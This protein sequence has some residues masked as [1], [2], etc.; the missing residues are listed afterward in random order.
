MIVNI[1]HRP[2]AGEL[3]DMFHLQQKFAHD[4][5]LKV[6]VMMPYDFLFDPEV[7]KDVKGYHLLYN[8]EIGVWFGEIANERINEVF[9]CKEPFLWLH[10]K[11]NKKRIIETVIE[12]FH[13]VFGMYPQTVGG[14]HMDAYSM[15]LIR[16]MCPSVKVSVAGCFEEGVKVYHG[17]NNSWY[18]FNEGMPWTPWYPSRENSLRPAE[19]MADW[20]G[21]VAVPHLV[22][23]MVLSYE[24]RNDFFASHPANIQRAM[25]NDG[26]DAPYVFNLL[27]MYRYQERYNN[28]FSYSNVFVGPNWLKGSAYVQDSDEVTQGLYKRYLEYFAELREQGALEDMYMS[29]FADWFREHIPAG[30]PQV[31][32]AKEILYGSGKTYF[33]YSDPWQRVT[34]DLCQGGSIGDL[35]PLVSRQERFTGAD[36]KE[37]AIG[38]NPY[39]IHSQ[40]RTGNAHHYADGARTTLILEY[41]GKEYD[42]ADFPVRIRKI[43]REKDR[44]RLE[45]ETIR[46]ELGDGAEAAAETAYEIEPGGKIRLLRRIR[47]TGDAGLH[48]KEYLKGCCGVTEYPEDLTGIR[49]RAEGREKKEITYRYEA[50]Q[51]RTG[52]PACVS[53]SIPALETEVILEADS[54]DFT[55]GYAEEGYVFNPY[56]TLALEGILPAGEEKEVRSCLRIT[57]AK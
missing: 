48:Y 49:L 22:R 32:E 40:Y 20:N 21:I 53:A 16:E 30:T 57:T 54:G 27:D 23:D 47:N 39:L 24:G 43:S 8:D 28:G 56:Y 13:E 18:L 33:W 11:E 14:Y 26:A 25:A 5:H 29:E 41:K 2:A 37:K 34:F 36:R 51:I 55:D 10:T 4:L 42:L 35:R 46:I 3:Y 38:S 52:E 44:V 6:T 1:M 19:S 17:C 9:R 45:L 31:Y 12:K 7:V 15:N 50:R